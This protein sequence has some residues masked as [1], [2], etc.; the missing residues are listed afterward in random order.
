MYVPYQG[1]RLPIKKSNFSGENIKKFQYALN[2]LFHKKKHFSLLSPLPEYRFERKF[3][4]K[5]K[6]EKSVNIC[7]KRQAFLLT[8]SVK[9]KDEYFKET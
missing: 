9:N 8:P 1:P 6:R 3:N 2:N 7:P 4:R 5:K